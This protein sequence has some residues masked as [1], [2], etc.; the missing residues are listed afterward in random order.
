[1]L[2][3]PH[4][5]DLS[6]E[7]VWHAADQT[8]YDDQWNHH[9]IE[10]DTK[11]ETDSTRYDDHKPDE[12]QITIAPIPLMLL[13]CEPIVVVNLVTHEILEGKVTK[14]VGETAWQEEQYC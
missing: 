3:S 13:L 1:M 9:Y 7:V 5:S 14:N 12:E 8:N 10:N 2:D 4:L 6:I 11:E